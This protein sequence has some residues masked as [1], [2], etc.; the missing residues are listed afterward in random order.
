MTSPKDS[1]KQ[2]NPRKSLTLEIHHP[3]T[4]CHRPQ[5]AYPKRGIPP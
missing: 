4:F 3:L 1:W 2:D 5:K